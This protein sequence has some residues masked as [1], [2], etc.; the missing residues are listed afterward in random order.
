[1]LGIDISGTDI[2]VR[3]FTATGSHAVAAKSGTNGCP[4]L[5]QYALKDLENLSLVVSALANTAISM[6]AL[7]DARVARQV[8]KEAV[9]GPGI[10][11]PDK[12]I[13][14]EGK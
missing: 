8:L 2:T 3:C 12:S 9:D 10:A 13:I 5:K 1:M 7:E 14:L 6:A 4:D 11:V